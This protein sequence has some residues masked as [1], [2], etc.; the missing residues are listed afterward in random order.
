MKGFHPK[1]VQQ[2]NS[3]EEKKKSQVD[4]KP[5]KVASGRC[6]LKNG[7]NYNTKINEKLTSVFSITTG[8]CCG[9]G[10]SDYTK[11]DGLTFSCST[12]RTNHTWT[13]IPGRGHVKS[14][15][16]IKIRE[17]VERERRDCDR[18]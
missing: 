8:D 16:Q 15:G 11:L 13:N 2:Q 10:W 3:S 14:R 4:R 9:R 17:E 7:G 1:K 18:S 12:E 5:E 6:N